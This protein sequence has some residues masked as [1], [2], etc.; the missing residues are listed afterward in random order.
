MGAAGKCPAFPPAMFARNNASDIND[1]IVGPMVNR[2]VIV[3]VLVSSS[4]RYL[5]QDIQ[6]EE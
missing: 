6:A 3:N 4:G 1:D 5:F 2:L